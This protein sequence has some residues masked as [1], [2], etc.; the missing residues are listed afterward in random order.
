M[1]MKM[2]LNYV[3]IVNESSGDRPHVLH[4]DHDVPKDGS[5]P[6]KKIVSSFAY[7]QIIRL[8]L[9][10]THQKFSTILSEVGC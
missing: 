2:C 8:N 6:D 5:S 3:V 1:T 4:D 7:A 10:M 9:D